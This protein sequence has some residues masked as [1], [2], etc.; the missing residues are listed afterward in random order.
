VVNTVLLLE[1]RDSTAIE[2]IVATIDRLSQ[3]L[4]GVMDRPSTPPTRR[5]A[6]APHCTGA[7]IRSETRFT[8][9]SALDI[10]RTLKGADMDMR[11]TPGTLP[12]R[13]HRGEVFYK[14]HEVRPVHAICWPTGSAS[15][16]RSGRLGP[17][18]WPKLRIS[19]TDLFWVSR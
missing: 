18:K 16:V 4:Q 9:P 14:P 3:Q 17:Q 5:F 8:P 10:F 11:R 19:R 2:N 15:W 6:T 7:F 12:P 13:D 1:A